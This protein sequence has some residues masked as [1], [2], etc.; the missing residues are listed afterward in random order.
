MMRNGEEPAS[1]CAC[2][3]RIRGGASPH[4]QESVLQQIFSDLMIS[5]HAVD[6]GVEASTVALIKRFHGP[7]C[8]AGNGIEQGFIAQLVWRS[9]IK[10]V[11]TPGGYDLL[12]IDHQSRQ[13]LYL[14]IV[15]N[16]FKL[17]NGV[18]ARTSYL[19]ALARSD[20]FVLTGSCS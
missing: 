10:S 9:V 20:C 3:R 2:L 6:Q 8:A 15:L 18:P 17:P 7:Y 5:N 13:F 11:Q 1:N 16:H 14:A 12:T 19:I 4:S